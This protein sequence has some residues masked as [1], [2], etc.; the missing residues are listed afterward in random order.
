[1][2][3][4]LSLRPSVRTCLAEGG[5]TVLVGLADLLDEAVDPEAFQQA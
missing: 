2:W 1:M 3:S 5:E 4:S